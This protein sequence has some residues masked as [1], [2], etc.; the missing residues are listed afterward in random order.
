[1]THP[2]DAAVGFGKLRLA[3]QTYTSGQIDVPLWADDIENG[4]LG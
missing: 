1:M 3:E 2:G 4:Y